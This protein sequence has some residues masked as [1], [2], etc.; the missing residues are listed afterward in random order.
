MVDANSK[1]AKNIQ[2]ESRDVSIQPPPEK[3]RLSPSTSPI[4]RTILK[5]LPRLKLIGSGMALDIRARAPW[6]MS[7]WID[8]WNYRVVPATALIFFAKSVRLRFRISPLI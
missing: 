1:D 6:Y 5:Q 3:R 4:I 7:D 2:V 8:A